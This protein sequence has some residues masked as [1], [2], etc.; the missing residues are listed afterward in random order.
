MDQPQHDDGLQVATEQVVALGAARAVGVVGRE[1]AHPEMTWVAFAG[2]ASARASLALVAT[3]ALNRHESLRETRGGETVWAA[4]FQGVTAGSGATVAIGSGSLPWQLALLDLLSEAACLTAGLRAERQRAARLQEWLTAMGRHVAAGNAVA[5][6]AH[7]IN[8][9][10]T[11]IIGEAQ[12]LQTEPLG[13]GM[14]ASLSAIERSGQRIRVAVQTVVQFSQS[15]GLAES[16]DVNA[17]IEAALGLVASQLEGAGVRL[18]ARLAPNLP[19]VHANAAALTEAWVHLLVN[20]W[21][22]IPSE[23]SGEVRI[24]TQLRQDTLLVTIADNGPVTVRRRRPVQPFA[25]ETRGPLFLAWDILTRAG[26]QVMMA[27]RPGMGTTIGVRLP[28]KTALK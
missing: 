2:P 20:A 25:P 16:T 19:P 8:N 4:T 11:T 15:D 22:A 24:A 18:T 3:E 26:G 12:L 21:Q 10:L 6:V 28:L 23:E 5:G 14:Q 1:A 27:S 17:T 13:P 7:R 9:P